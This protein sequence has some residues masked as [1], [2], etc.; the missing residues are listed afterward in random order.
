MLK[1]LVLL[2]L[3]TNK[4][5]NTFAPLHIPARASPNSQS[6]VVCVFFLP[7]ATAAEDGRQGASFNTDSCFLLCAL[8]SSPASTHYDWRTSLPPVL[9][10]SL[11]VFLGTAWVCIAPVSHWVKGRRARGG[12]GQK[13]AQMGEEITLN[14]LESILYPLYSLWQVWQGMHAGKVVLSS[15]PYSE[16]EPSF[17]RVKLLL[18][19]LPC[20]CLCYKKVP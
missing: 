2:Y 8:A 5:L 14:L 1:I 7:F 12:N 17:R 16:K 18:L 15:N 19:L 11:C 13:A 9:F 10:L 3:Y 20:Y 4:V 6:Y